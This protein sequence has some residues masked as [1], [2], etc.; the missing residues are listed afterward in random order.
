MRGCSRSF[1]VVIERKVSVI[2]SRTNN[3]E[4]DSDDIRCSMVNYVI[5]EVVVKVVFHALYS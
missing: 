3:Y 5:E 2:I 1:H 4:V